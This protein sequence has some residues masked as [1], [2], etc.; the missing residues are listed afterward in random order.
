M[1]WTKNMLFLIEKENLKNS[2]DSS[3]WHRKF[4]LKVIFWDF[5]HAISHCNHNVQWF[6][7]S[8][9]FPNIFHLF[10]IQCYFMPPKSPQ[11]QKPMQKYLE[12][13]YFLSIARKRTA[14]RFMASWPNNGPRLFVNV[15]TLS[16]DIILLLKPTLSASALPWEEIFFKVEKI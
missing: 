8:I 9:F 2:A 5:W 13:L 10:R 16:N 15:F 11:N 12:F 3:L 1:K 4:I 6:P 14:F 7:L